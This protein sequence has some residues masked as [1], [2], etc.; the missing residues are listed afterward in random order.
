LSYLGY[1]FA[2]GINNSGYIIII[3]IYIY[4]L[5]GRQLLFEKEKELNYRHCLWIFEA[6]LGRSRSQQCKV[7]AYSRPFSKEAWSN[8]SFVLFS[9]LGPSLINKIIHT[10]RKYAAVEAN[11]DTPKDNGPLVFLLY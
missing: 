11:M 9:K 1:Q 4:Y 7:T 8:A 5:K 3:I 6:T 2:S 10:T